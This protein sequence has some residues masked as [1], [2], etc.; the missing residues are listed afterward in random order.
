MVSWTDLQLEKQKRRNRRKS[1]LNDRFKV[2][3]RLRKQW[4]DLDWKMFYVSS[5]WS[6]IAV[7]SW[8]NYSY[9]V[10]S[11]RCESIPLNRRTRHK[12]KQALRTGDFDTSKYNLKLPYID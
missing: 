8:I 5:E 3:W 2:Q 11:E 4:R 1:E 9:T 10:F 12:V 6:D 7:P